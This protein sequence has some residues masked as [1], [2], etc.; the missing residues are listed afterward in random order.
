MPKPLRI[1]IIGMMCVL[2][3]PFVMLALGIPFY[4]YGIIA[5]GI[6]VFGGLIWG[7][8]ALVSSIDIYNRN[9]NSKNGL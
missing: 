1:Y 8:I 9:T 6:C 4:P 7:L 5:K 2:L 3:I